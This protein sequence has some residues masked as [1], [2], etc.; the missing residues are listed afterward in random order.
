[1]FKKEIFKLL[2]LC[3]FNTNYREYAWSFCGWPTIF[4]K[5]YWEEYLKE[6]SK[7]FENTSHKLNS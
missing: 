5:F 3:W 7:Y 4:A 1:M 2:R 6:N